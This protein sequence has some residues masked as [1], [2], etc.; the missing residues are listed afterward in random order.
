MI[1]RDPVYGGHCVHPECDC[2]CRPG[3]WRNKMIKEEE[4]KN[5]KG[6][7]RGEER[8]VGESK[9][10]EGARK[11]LEPSGSKKV[12]FLDGTAETE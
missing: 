7:I 10:V 12:A 3:P 5:V 4:E 6:V 1:S 11:L 9:A 8:K 2:C